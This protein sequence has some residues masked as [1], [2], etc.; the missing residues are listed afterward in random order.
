[1][2]ITWTEKNQQL[3][4]LDLVPFFNAVPFGSHAKP[5]LLP[6]ECTVAKCGSLEIPI[7]NVELGEMT[8]TTASRMNTAA[9]PQSIGTAALCKY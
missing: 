1:M 3:A 8:F 5:T 7:T 6:A 2:G 9:Q 4:P